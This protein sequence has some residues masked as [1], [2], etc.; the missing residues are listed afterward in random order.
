MGRV[1]EKEVKRESVKMRKI[2]AKINGK[3]TGS[4]VSSLNSF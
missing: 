2:G 1:K 3:D 4:T